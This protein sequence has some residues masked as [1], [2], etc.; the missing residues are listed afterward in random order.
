MRRFASAAT[1]VAATALVVATVAASHAGGPGPGSSGW[2]GAG[3]TVAFADTY[4]SIASQRIYFV[5]PDRYANGDPANDR[6]GA[7]GRGSRPASTRLT[8]AGITAVT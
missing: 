2:R 6:G 1:A 8:R 3:R 4:A 5:M 7:S